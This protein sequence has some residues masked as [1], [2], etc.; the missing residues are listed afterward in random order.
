MKQI[1]VLVTC[2]ACS[3][4]LYSPPTQAYTLAPVAT[5]APADKA[6]DVDLST[7]SQIFDPGYDQASGRLRYGIT[8]AAELSIEGAAATIEGS[9]GPSNHEIYSSRAGVR[10]QPGKGPLS[11]N[12]G[13]G[14]GFA[15]AAGYFAAIDTGA[16]IGFD[17]CY[18]V[19]IAAVSTFVSQPLQ[20]KAVAVGETDTGMTT[21]STPR[22]TAGG[23]V[24]FG[25]RLPMLHA[26]CRAGKS[27]PTVSVGIDLSSVVDA[28]DHAEMLGVGIGVTVPL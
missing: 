15:P 5:L 28:S 13:F 1:V 26:D 24:R 19:P 22:R 4:H 9:I 14:G 10:W 17:N 3:Q 8:P 16:Q 6:L 21:Y 12:A 20:A 7:H 2:A 11:L 23:T 27:V 18:F 25:A